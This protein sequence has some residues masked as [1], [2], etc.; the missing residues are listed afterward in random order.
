MNLYYKTGSVFYIFLISFI[1]SVHTVSAAHWIAVLC[2]WSAVCLQDQQRG[3]MGLS[4]S[5]KGVG[6]ID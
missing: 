1:L 5:K 3:D 4:F 6:V 2:K